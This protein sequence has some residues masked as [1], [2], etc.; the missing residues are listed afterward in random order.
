MSSKPKKE[1]KKERTSLK[2]QK[3]TNKHRTVTNNKKSRRRKKEMTG[4]SGLAYSCTSTCVRSCYTW[5]AN[6]VA[7]KNNNREEHHGNCQPS[8]SHPI[9]P[10]SIPPIHCHIYLGLKLDPEMTMEPATKHTCQKINWAYQTVSA[11]AHSLK[12][13]I[14]ASLRG[15]RTSPLILYRIWQSCVLSHATQNL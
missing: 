2:K 12:H 11:I 5:R 6:C 8:G 4:A 15:T 3:T 13:D 9:S 1:K 7:T 10:L 14:P